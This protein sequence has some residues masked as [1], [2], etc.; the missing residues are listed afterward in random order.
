[1]LS[2]SQ[3]SQNSFKEFP[4]CLTLLLSYFIRKEPSWDS[5]VDSK[6]RANRPFCSLRLT[7]WPC[8]IQISPL[9]ATH[10][11]IVPTG[12]VSTDC[13][14]LWALLWALWRWRGTKF[15]K[16]TW[17]LES[18]RNSVSGAWT[19]PKRAPFRP[20]CSFKSNLDASIFPAPNPASR[21]DQ[22]PDRCQQWRSALA[23]K[24]Q[25][26][27]TGQAANTQ[28]HLLQHLIQA[29]SIWVAWRAVFD[30]RKRSNWDWGRRAAQGPDSHP[31][32][33]IFKSFPSES[34]SAYAIVLSVLIATG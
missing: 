27:E 21:A 30:E 22:P 2:L 18:R 10:S 13:E 24:V 14:G 1:M 26:Q 20:K 29:V 11:T 6:E 12:D 3:V 32:R 8:H 7:R 31:I 15:E 34:D 17:K 23:E 33:D 4:V 9:G 16:G 28:R 25:F 5:P 19:R